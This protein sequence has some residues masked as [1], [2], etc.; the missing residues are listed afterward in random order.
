MYK[1][2]LNTNCICMCQ[3]A[4]THISNSQICWYSSCNMQYFEG[5]VSEFEKW[6]L[7]W[8]T[9][10]RANIANEIRSKNLSTSWNDRTY[11]ISFL[12]KLCCSWRTLKMIFFSQ[13]FFFGINL[14]TF[15]FRMLFISPGSTSHYLIGF[16]TTLGCQNSVIYIFLDLQII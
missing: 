7:I 6:L 12:W 16:F 10:F 4:Y 2:N 8:G 15:Q 13:E 11:F 1:I 5:C 3:Y 14:S 9:E